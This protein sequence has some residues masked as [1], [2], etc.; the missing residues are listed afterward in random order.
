MKQ[1]IIPIEVFLDFARDKNR[2]YYRLS[3]WPVSRSFPPKH[4]VQVYTGLADLFRNILVKDCSTEKLS[5]NIFLDVSN[6]K[7]WLQAEESP[8]GTTTYIFPSRLHRG[9]ALFIIL[10]IYK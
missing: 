5:M 1:A 7:G 2:L 8:D 4:L 9:Y 6:K 10:N 3:N